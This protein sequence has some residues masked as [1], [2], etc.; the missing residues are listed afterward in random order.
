MGEN[1]RVLEQSC[2]PK[3]SP[4][5]SINIQ[6]MSIQIHSTH[7]DKKR[8]EAFLNSLDL[9]LEHISYDW[10]L[11]KESSRIEDAVQLTNSHRSLLITILFVESYH[12]GDIIAKANFSND[13][14]RWGMNGSLMYVVES[15]DSNV[16][17]SVLSAFAG[18]E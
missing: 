9:S 10:K 18:K 13:T 16:V 3:I 12:D 8:A 14:T 17:S 1:E 4:R 11:L 2:I 7:P 5:I 6:F 15:I